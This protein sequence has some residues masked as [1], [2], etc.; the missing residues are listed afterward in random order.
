MRRIISLG[1][2]ICGLALAGCEN[3][4][5]PPVTTCEPE[6]YTQE[7]LKQLRENTFSIDNDAARQ[8]LA[9]ALLDCLSDS[10]PGIRDGIAFEGL[11]TWMRTKKL[12]AETIR[13][14]KQTLLEKVKDGKNTNG[15]EKPF[16]A[17]VL[18]EI[19]RIDRVTPFMSTY[20]R[21]AF[22]VASA[23]YMAAIK[24]YRGFNNREGWRH[25][26]A[27]GADWLMQLSLNPQITKADAVIIRG[28]VA[29]QIRADN[30]H[31]FIHGEPAR[32]AMPI[33]FLASRGIFTEAEW[34]AWLEQISAPSPLSNWNAAFNT[35]SG[36]AQRHNLKQFLNAVYLNA[37]LSDS[38]ATRQLLTGTK[39][40]LKKLP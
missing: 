31:A 20:D 40:A 38:D 23:D 25:N 26:V 35:E 3:E 30:K 8:T 14:I 17:L 15:F 27:H 5:L 7:T 10:N 12:N 24:D 4:V 19:A 13:T 36:L 32:L 37:T 21:T 1:V 39:A 28:A 11:A 9:I 34:T 2:I 6:G 22:V 16:A 33:L 18:A 29:S